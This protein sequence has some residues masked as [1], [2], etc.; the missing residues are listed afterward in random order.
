MK[1]I[2][3]I[4]QEFMYFTTAKSRVEQFALKHNLTVTRA[5]QLIRDNAIFING[6]IYEVAK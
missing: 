3:Y 2:N 1:L 4:N 5:W 6:K